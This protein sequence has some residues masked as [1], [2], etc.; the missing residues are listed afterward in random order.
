MMIMVVVKNCI[1]NG[2]GENYDENGDGENYN[3][4]GDGKNQQ[5]NWRRAGFPLVLTLSF[6]DSLDGDDDDVM[7]MMDGGWW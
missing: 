3:E 6:S 1:E 5:E 2:D 7:I 4:N